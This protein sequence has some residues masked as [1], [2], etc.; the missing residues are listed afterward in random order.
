V[1]MVPRGEVGM[2][3]ASIGLSLGVI[4]SDLY[5]VVIFMVIATTLMT[6]P[7]LAKMISRKYVEMKEE[8][9]IEEI[10]VDL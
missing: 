4:S 6:P 7:V 5:A 8:E 3:V 1:G 2:I 10:P 9:K